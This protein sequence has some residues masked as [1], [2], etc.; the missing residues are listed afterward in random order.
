VEEKRPVRLAT[1]RGF[2]KNRERGERV[3]GASKS[4]KNSHGCTVYRGGERF[5]STWLT[6]SGWG[7]CLPDA[8]GGRRVPVWLLRG[9]GVVV[10]R[11]A[12][13]SSTQWQ[14]QTRMA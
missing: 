10:R 7:R 4:T 11:A 9:G 1:H 6:A 2:L 8:E 12:V 5:E 14:W 3:I 13:G